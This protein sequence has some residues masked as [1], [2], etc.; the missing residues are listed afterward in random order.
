VFEFEEFEIDPSKKFFIIYGK[1]EGDLEESDQ[2]ILSSCSTSDDVFLF[3]SLA[4]SAIS[5]AN[6]IIP[7]EG[8]ILI[9]IAGL[10]NVISTRSSSSISTSDNQLIKR[11]VEAYKLL[12]KRNIRSLNV[13]NY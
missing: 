12:N 11:I 6:S 5:I 13:Y 2:T 4:A 10:E 1:T 3:R 7:G 8:E 9:E